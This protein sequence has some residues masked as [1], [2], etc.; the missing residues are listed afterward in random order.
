[1]NGNTLQI[2]N[3]DERTIIESSFQNKNKNIKIMTKSSLD[4]K[5]QFNL[6]MEFNCSLNL[7]E[8]NEK[9]LSKIP[10]EF[11]QGMINIL[12]KSIANTL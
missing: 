8:I 7:S 6:H 9:Y 5:K 4:N 12:A 2:H 10:A 3:Q 1:M 11:K